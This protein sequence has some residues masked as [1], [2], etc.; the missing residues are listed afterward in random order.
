M[1]QVLFQYR[2]RRKGIL[3]T[4]IPDLMVATLAIQNRKLVFSTDEHFPRMA[5]HIPLRLFTP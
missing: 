4:G 3:D 2:L 5:P 1:S